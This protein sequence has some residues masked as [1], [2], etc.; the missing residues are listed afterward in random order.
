MIGYLIQKG[1]VSVLVKRELILL[2]T[3]LEIIKVGN[4][5]SYLSQIKQ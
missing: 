4:D 1:K 2:D 3:L 5:Y